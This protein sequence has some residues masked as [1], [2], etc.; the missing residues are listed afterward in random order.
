MVLIMDMSFSE[1]IIQQS[2][3][4]TEAG[5]DMYTA[6]VCLCVEGHHGPSSIQ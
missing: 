2:T 4:K 6:Q 1:V 5:L 3:D